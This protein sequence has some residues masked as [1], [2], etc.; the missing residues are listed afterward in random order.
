MLRAADSIGA[1][2]TLTNPL[3]RGT[4]V[5]VVENRETW[6]KVRIASGTVGWVP[7]GAVQRITSR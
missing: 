6:A 1:P 5:T 7:A 3:P 2:A 4:E